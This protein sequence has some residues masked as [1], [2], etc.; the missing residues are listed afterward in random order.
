MG[1]C[2]FTSKYNYL[3]LT[4]PV[5]LVFLLA[6]PGIVEMKSSKVVVLLQQEKLMEQRQREDT[7]RARGQQQGQRMKGKRRVSIR[8][9]FKQ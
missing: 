1:P 6:E 8:E 2:R 5:S 4:M 3:D 7:R 9:L